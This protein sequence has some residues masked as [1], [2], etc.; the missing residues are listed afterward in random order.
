MHGD[1]THGARRQAAG[2]HLNTVVV[3]DDRVDFD[4]RGGREILRR[5]DEDR[6]LVGVDVDAKEPVNQA[7]DEPGRVDRAGS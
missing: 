1:G 3:E 4:R 7:V 2:G 5:R 6:L